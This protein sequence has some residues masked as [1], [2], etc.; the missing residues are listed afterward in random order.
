MTA[1]CLICI[2]LVSGLLTTVVG[3]A[4]TSQVQYF[5]AVDPATS[6][7]NYYKMT[8]EGSSGLLARYKL[9]AGYFNA[10]TLDALTGSFSDPPEVSG[11]EEALQTFKDIDKVFRDALKRDADAA[12]ALGPSPENLIRIARARY[13][14]SLDDLSINSIGK[15]ESLNPYVFQKLVFWAEAEPVN[16]QQFQGQFENI[17][18]NSMA[19]VKGMRARAEQ[20]RKE[21]EQEEQQKNSLVHT[22][23]G[24]GE[25][26]NPALKP[27]F[28]MVRKNFPVDGDDPNDNPPDGG[29]QPP[30]GD[31][32]GQETEAGSGGSAA[33]E[34]TQPEGGA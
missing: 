23:L 8:V 15:T 18:K 3:C 19:V 7:I 6:N 9:R 12:M 24:Y 11:D 31:G 32:G 13:L 20:R 1:R 29:G 10:V 4:T 27:V 26:S 34:S 25:I 33:A 21:K 17:I 30:G 22:A 16:L 28:D 5:A 2:G 14:A